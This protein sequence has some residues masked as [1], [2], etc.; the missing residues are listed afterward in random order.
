MRIRDLVLTLVC[1]FSIG[2]AG[3]STSQLSSPSGDVAVKFKLTEKGQLNYS[4]MLSDAVLLKDSPLGLK[5][6]NADFTTGLEVVKI[7]MPK[8]ITDNYTMV[9]GK[10]LDCSYEANQVIITLHNKQG[11]MLDVVFQ[12]SNDSVAMRYILKGTGTA[13]ITNEIT[14]YNFEPDTL[15]WLHPMH[16]AKTGW[17][18]AYPSY[19]SQYQAAIK[20]LDSTASTAGWSYP[21]LYQV[22][23]NWV[24][25]S[26]TDLDGTYCATRLTK[27]AGD[28]G[29]YHIDFPQKLENRGE[30]DPVAP[31]VTLPFTSPWRIIALGDSLGDIVETTVATDLASPSKVKDTSWIKPGK[32]AWS[33]LCYDDPTTTM[34]W[35]EKFLDM[36]IDLNWEY[37][38]V[39]ALWDTQIGYD[40]IAQLTK[41]ANENGVGIILWYNSNGEWNQ[42]PQTPLN[43]MHKRDVRRAEF[44]RISEMGV[45]G[46][47]VDFFGGDKQATMNLYMDILADAA[48]YGISVNFHGA[49]LP[50][51]WQ[52]T[53]PNMVST[54]AVMGMEYCT[55]SQDTMNRQPVH[56]S[57]LPYTRNVVA[58]MDFTPTVLQRKVRGSNRQTSYVFELALMT[59]FESGVQHLG[60][61]PDE[62]AIAKTFVV[63]YL[64]N[65]PTAWQQTKF[66]AG[67][68]AKDFIVA[69]RSGNTWYI[70]GINGENKNKTMA[71]DLS[72]IAKEISGDMICDS[73]DSNN[74]ELNKIENV[75]SSSVNVRMNAV[76]GFILIVDVK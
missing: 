47:K 15:S 2:I 16:D 68:P 62:A 51:G 6:T 56:C 65:V 53:W 1:V 30:I 35:Q 73:S 67:Y 42:A 37:V 26:E 41:K 7:S 17:A 40:K 44:K 25:I 58:P 31:S 61:V 49:T 43:K 4:V 27:N 48:D 33:W 36:A 20:V 45:Q 59:A 71:I 5:S 8:I 76:G 10:K 23:S 29:L 24:L 63:D 52:R 38:L 14:G 18:G 54:E 57:I 11:D 46:I 64:R 34:E 21:A 72:F 39:D 66:V 50:R 60:V 9:H 28:A 13:S 3:C 55:F 70:A 75:D 22:G 69:R 32:S 19:E 12:V 74:A